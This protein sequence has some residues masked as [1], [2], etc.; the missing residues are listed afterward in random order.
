MIHLSDGVYNGRNWAQSAQ[1]S[2]YNGYD[3][4]EAERCFQVVL[5]S[6]EVTLIPPYRENNP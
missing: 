2:C 5:L 6:T 4:P 1:F 3:N